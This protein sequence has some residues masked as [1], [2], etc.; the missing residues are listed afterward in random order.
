VIGEAPGAEERLAG[1]P[2]V[3]R[4]GKFLYRSLADVGLSRREIFVTSVEERRRATV[5]RPARRSRRQAAP[6]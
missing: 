5:R 6:A 4:D 3:G 2:F 1:R